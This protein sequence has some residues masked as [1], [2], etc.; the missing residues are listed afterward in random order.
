MEEIN[1]LTIIATAL[2][3]SVTATLA[4]LWYKSKNHSERIAKLETK[5]SKLR[6]ILAAKFGD[7]DV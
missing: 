5:M 6:R 7:S 3:S 1:A 4:V 2:Q